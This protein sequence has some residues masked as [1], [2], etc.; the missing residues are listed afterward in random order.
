MTITTR[1]MGGLG[2]QLFQYA[3]GRILARQHKTDLWLDDG[4]LGKSDN[5]ITRRD[6]EL[7]PFAIN[8]AGVKPCQPT[9]GDAVVAEDDMKSPQE[10]LTAPR[11]SFLIG[12]W[13]GA[14]YLNHLRDELLETIA[15][16][17]TGNSLSA[18]SKKMLAMMQK[19]TSVFIHIRRGD[20]AQ[21]RS[22]NKFHG[23]LPLGYYQRAIK[24]MQQQLPNATFF[25]FS[26][27]P[28]WVKQN[29]PINNS[30]KNSQT[31]YVD[32]NQGQDSWQDLILMS[33]CKHA[34][35]ANS[36]FSFW[37]AY[38]LWLR[39]QRNRP[40]IIAPKQWFRQKNIDT[41]RWFPPDWQLLPAQRRSWLAGFYRPLSSLW[42][43]LKKTRHR[44]ISEK[45]G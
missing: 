23:L 19:T 35:I 43:L 16:R 5:N 21:L 20:Y 11:N 40:H 32:H 13:Q 10:L 15:P 41:A 45:D 8:I 33:H 37:G 2:N 31:I 39:H 9:A 7:S 26:D 1:L 12:Y 38:L 30:R 4:F 3:A 36:S 34:I 17:K 22:A 29:L 6:Y 42:R 44:L 25:I 24:I 28:A 27:D 14:F 18:Q